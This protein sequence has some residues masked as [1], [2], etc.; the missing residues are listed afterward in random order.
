MTRTIVHSP[1]FCCFFTQMQMWFL[2]RQN[3]KGKQADT[4]FAY[5]YTE[6]TSDV[7]TSAAEALVELSTKSQIISKKKKWRSFLLVSHLMIYH[8]KKGIQAYFNLL[9]L[10]ALVSHGERG[11]MGACGHYTVIG[12]PPHMGRGHFSV[13]ASLFICFQPPLNP[14][15]KKRKNIMFF[16]FFLYFFFVC[17]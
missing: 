13:V 11:I 8:F 12:Y 5:R 10:T 6:K 1:D 9:C 3:W 7:C 16:F 14:C 15:K 17:F 2:L 4:L